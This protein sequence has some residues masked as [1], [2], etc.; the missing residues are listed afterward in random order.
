MNYGTLMK[1]EWFGSACSI[2]P[3]SAIFSNI[4]SAWDWFKLTGTSASGVQAACM[5]MAM[6][7]HALLWHALLH[8]YIKSDIV[9][10]TGLTTTACPLRM[11]CCARR[12]ADW[13]SKPD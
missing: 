13:H 7:K 4:Q 10:C 11:P 9:Q 6:A 2:H 8:I 1:A 12:A 5:V 3:K